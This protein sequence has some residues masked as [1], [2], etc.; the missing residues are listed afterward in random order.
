MIIYREIDGVQ[1]T[2]NISLVEVDATTDRIRIEHTVT[3]DL[4]GQDLPKGKYLPKRIGQL[5]YPTRIIE[6][7]DVP[8]GQWVPAREAL[9]LVKKHL[10]EAYTVMWQGRGWT[11]ELA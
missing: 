5:V 8:R 7:V 4:A 6:Y 9:A 3:P 1:G 2:M 10:G 11:I